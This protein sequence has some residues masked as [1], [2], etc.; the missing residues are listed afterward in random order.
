[1]TNSRVLSTLHALRHVPGVFGSFLW[2]D[3]G[4]LMAADL[5]PGRTAE[6]MQIATRRLAAIATAYASA[7]ECLQHVTLAYQQY[8]L[9]ISGLANASLV[10]VLSRACSLPTILPVIDDVLRELTRMPELGLARMGVTAFNEPARPQPVAAR[11]YRGGR[12][13]E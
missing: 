5:T 1:M 12:I 7:G 2:M 4:R 11:S 3:D 10:V 9:H 13:F 6:V 8:Q